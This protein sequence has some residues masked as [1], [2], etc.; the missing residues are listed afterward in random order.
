MAT[1]VKPLHEQLLAQ[2][3]HLATKDRNP[4]PPQASLRRAVS[5]AYYA[6]FH[7][8]IHAAS[9]TLAGGAERKYLSHLLSRAFEHGEMNATCKSFASGTLP[10]SITSN[11]GG[12]TSVPADLRAVAN[13]FCKLQNA[14]HLADYAV[15]QPVSRTE[16]IDMIA[17]AKDAFDAWARIGSDPVAR[18]F[19]TCLLV[20]K[21]L[22]G[23]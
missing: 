6:L 15:H 5:T 23:R 8:L 17:V 16:A 21:K 14:R 22:Q 1:R 2:A 7:L 12:T 11:Y 4:N 9:S 10:Q 13:A 19:L 20:G 3:T 18:L